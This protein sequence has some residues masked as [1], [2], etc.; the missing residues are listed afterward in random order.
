MIIS[1]SPQRPDD[2]VAASRPVHPPG[3]AP[4]PRRPARC[5][6][7]GSTP[8]PPPGPH[9]LGRAGRRGAGRR[10]RT[11]RLAVREVGKPLAEARG[12][13]ARAVSILRYYAQQPFAE[14]A[15]CISRPGSGLLFTTRRPRGLAGL[16]TPWNFPFAIPLWK[17]AP[18]LAYGN[19]VLLE[20]AEQATGCA[21]RLQELLAAVLPA[22][23]CCRATR[24]PAG[25]SSSRP[26]WSPSPAPPLSGGRCWRP[27]HSAAS[28]CRPRSAG[29]TRRSCCR[30]PTSPAAARSIA[31]AVAGYAGQKCT[32]TKRVLVVG[33]PAPFTETLVAA[34]AAGGGRSGP[35]GRRGRAGDR[36]RGPG[37]GAGGRRE[38]RIGRRPGA[39]RGRST[40]RRHRLVRRPH[41]GVRAAGGPPAGVRRGVRPDL[42]GQR[43]RALDEAISRANSVQQGLVAGLY[44][45]DLGGALAAVHRLGRPA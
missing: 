11:R 39:D 8:A 31:A 40:G 13:I 25:P 33:D 2:I 43:G 37:P 24:T 16:I 5:S 45:R 18:A 26:T 42:L 3:C 27:R 38:C 34:V 41:R 12:E 30:T 7:S 20:P 1:T 35:G 22:G 14:P 36:R 23:P 21:L 9:A 44:T 29:R 28:R 19:A 32:A 4:P 10:R 6:R 17:A 15:R